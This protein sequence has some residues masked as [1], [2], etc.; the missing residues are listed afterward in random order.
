MRTLILNSKNIVA[1]TNNSVLEYNFPAGSVYLDKAY[2][3][4]Q[5][6][7]M[8]Y[9]TFNITA[10]Y[11]NN[12]MS[13][14][15]IDGNT[16]QVV[17]PDGYYDATGIQ[18]Y[19]RSVML[20]NKHYLQDTATGQIIWFF[21][22]TENPSSYSIQ[23]NFF[24]INTTQYPSASY[25]NPSTG[26]ATAWT[27]PILANSKCPYVTIPNNNFGLLIGFAPNNYP[28]IAQSNTSTALS[29]LSTFAPQLSPLSSYILTCSLANNNFSIPNSLLFCFAPV[30]TIGEQFTIS[31]YSFSFIPIL[32]GSYTS[33]RVQ[34]TDQNN[35]PVAIQDPN[36]VVML[37]IADEDEVKGRK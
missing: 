36:Y 10:A 28:S 15:W 34:L 11:N 24:P 32:T 7:T 3:A 2:V 35:L 27:V 23:M 22:L 20:S 30:G 6:L 19:I 29:F 21:G 18:D 25:Y 33:F 13:Y 31:P 1:N 8:Y 26:T 16:F 5:T 9:S 37:V 14:T 4:L 12:K 17:F